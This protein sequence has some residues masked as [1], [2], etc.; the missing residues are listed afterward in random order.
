M[1]QIIISR[2]V[3]LAPPTPP[4]TELSPR[5]LT[6]IA[7]GDFI[8]ARDICFIIMSAVLLG[9][10]LIF[11]VWAFHRFQKAG[12]REPGLPPGPPTLPLIGN[13]HIFP[14]TRAHLKFT[15]WA[16]VYGEIYSLKIGTGT[17]VVLSSPKAVRELLDLRGATTSDR[18]PIH[19]IELVSRGYELPLSRYGP[20]WRTLRRAA[21]DMLTKEACMQHLP[22]QRAEACQVMYDFLEHPEQFYTHIHRYTT[23]VVL[24]VIF[25][26]HCQKYEN[27]FVEDFYDSQRQF[28]R[29]LRPG[30]MP[31]VD[32][33]PILKHIPEI[34]APWK[35]L[36]R[37]IR[38]RQRKL[39]F[40]LVDVCVERIKHGKRNECF[41]EYLLDNQE[42][43]NL[44]H[45]MLG[46]VGGSLLEAGSDTSAVFLQFFIA[47]MVAR[48]DIQARAQQE[49]DAVVGFK[50][51]PELEDFESLPFLNAILNEVHRFRPITPTGLPHA[52]TEDERV[53]EY[54]IPKGT[55]LFLNLWGI[56]QNEEY[57]ERPGEFDPDRFL[58]S[59][60]GTK[61]GA[62][63]TGMRNDLIFGAGRRICPGMHLAGNSIA[64]NT[65]NFL[66]AFNLTPAK[67]SKTGEVIPVDLN[68]TTDGIL[69]IPKPFKCGIQ[70]RSEAKAEMIRAQFKAAHSVFELFEQDVSISAK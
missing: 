60:F 65:M 21:H 49:I 52:T 20:L 67:D 47:C 42:R 54:V 69:L 10:V 35:T 26:I 2:F 23:S 34:L 8:A 37:D 29:L 55:T 62:D 50:R 1:R 19:A 40:G 61:S 41:M 46:Y 11:C 9:S 32:V 39:F 18:P 3:T 57:Y 16:K 31:P 30:G 28:E 44:D 13:L 70:P 5:L 56:F 48:P 24:S 45:E 14:S 64:L 25:G 68:E 59:E 12:S 43:Y 33:F 6:A 27:T 7:R 66:W 51:I 63:L 53:G 15:E 38:H 17:A 36:C 22:I 4:P 58:R